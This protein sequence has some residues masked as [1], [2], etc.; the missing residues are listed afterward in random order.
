MY[1]EAPAAGPDPD[2]MGAT[3]MSSADPRPTRPRFVGRARERQLLRWALDEVAAGRGV[4]L[5][6]T[7]DPGIG[8]TRLLLDLADQAG[9]RGF[10]VLRGT[11]TE[12]ERDRPFHVFADALAD[13]YRRDQPDTAGQGWLAALFAGREAP[14]SGAERFRLFD[15]VRDLLA[16]WSGDGLALLL[17]DMHW[18]DPGT[19]EL[20]DYLIRRP[21]PGPLLLVLAHRGRQSPAR[22]AGT[23]ARGAES[24]T[25]TRAEIGPLSAAEAADLAG[26]ELDEAARETILAESAGNPLYLLAARAALTAAGSGAGESGAPAGF[27]V[28]APDWAPTRLEAVLLAELA[29]LT[30]GQS[31]VAAA[32]AIAGEPFSIESLSA[33]TGLPQAEVT[34]AVSVLTGRDVLRPSAAGGFE[35][36]HPV[37]RRVVYR[38]C[39]PAWRMAAHRR[40]L[41]DLARRDAAATELAHHVAAAPGDG[42]PGDTEIL[43]TAAGSVL[44]TAPATA[45][46]W[47]RICLR[48]LP[49]DDSHAAQRLEVLL[50]LTRALGVAGRLGESRDL[51]HE[52]IRVVPVRPPGPRV[53]A[54]TFC[55]TMERLLA[56]YPEA[57]AMLAAE[58]ASPRAAATPQGIPLAI[59]YATVALLSGDYPA[60]RAELGAALARARRGPSRVREAHAAAMSAFGEVYE[61][62]VRDS[63]AAA[64]AAAALV[65][66]LADGDLSD[67]PECL[68]VLGWA[69]LFLDRHL[70]AGRHFARGVSISRNSGIYHVL[71]HLLLGQ[72]QL[73]IFRGPL[74]QAIA[75]SEDA[76]E[77]ARHIDSGD[78][79]GL[80]L[81][82]R[83][84]ALAWTGGEEAKR[85]VDLAERGAASIPPASV[86]WTRTVAIYHGLTL[87]LSGDPAR[88]MSVITGAGGGDA[89]PLIQPSVRAAVLDMLTA[90]AVLAGDN[91]RARDWSRYAE[92]ESRRTG[93][94]R[95]R[96]YAVR[97][98]GYVLSATGRRA[99][100]VGAYQEA[101]G[102]FGS[103]GDTVAQ[104]W[105]LAMGADSALATGRPDTAL[106]MATAASALA[107]AVGSRTTL[108][109]A[110]A[111]RQ[112]LA[113]PDGSGDPLAALTGRER[114]IARLAAT[115]SS[116]RDIAARLQLSPRTV[117]THL[118]RVYHKLG[119]RSRAGLASLLAGPRP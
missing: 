10:P 64:D 26:A 118:S 1:P 6:V 82:L 97:A 18:A 17:D 4:T 35:F 98:R 12:F 91:D 103:A 21:L 61:G 65:D 117:D 80:A 72:C 84:A 83:A 110:D 53:A 112:R 9:Q 54:V 39:D 3:A 45:A 59:E 94:T 8:K 102:L 75:L 37:L 62:N 114:E 78:V 32:G 93:L 79:L 104:G 111:V 29:P 81:G 24:G 46:H 66:T 42:Q 113:G 30:A 16:D 40:A 56:R 15:A 13:R 86:W 19:V 57:R 99:E 107:K 101:A 44:S 25:V 22:L 49:A 87:L 67:A 70:D 52:I 7:G 47:L 106:A 77:I 92:T 23:L 27:A 105:A 68:A 100:A 96:G 60:A 89:L 108:G 14:G 33:I 48:M 74:D 55:A 109:M 2:A 34:A 43:L 50:L 5:E 115:G 76:E 36:R 20:T 73:A 69:E 11:A 88:C 51:L 85:A 71:P 116:T 28:P 31:A 119:V 90:A 38:D 95:Q 41:T 58:L 63:A